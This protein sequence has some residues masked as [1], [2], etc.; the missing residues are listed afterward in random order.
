VF[1][2]MTNPSALSEKMPPLIQILCEICYQIIPFSQLL[3]NLSGHT[4]KRFYKKKLLTGCFYKE[5]RMFWAIR[6]SF[7]KNR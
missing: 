7:A 2:E 6:A 1:E 3:L 5:T 4:E